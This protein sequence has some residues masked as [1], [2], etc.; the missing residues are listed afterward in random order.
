MKTYQT[1]STR[2]LD[3][4]GDATRRS[5]LDLLRGG[6]LAVGEIAAHLPVSRPAVSQHLRVLKEA[7]LVRD[8]REGTRRV[9]GIAPEGLTALREYLDGFWTQALAAFEQAAASAAERKGGRTMNEL[10]PIHKAVEV[11]IGPEDAFRLFTRDIGSWW[12]V[13][14]HSR[15]AA[16]HE[17]EGITVERVEFQEAVGGRVIEHLSD[18]RTLPWAEVLAW[19][20]PASFVLSWHPSSASRP[21]TAVEVRFTPTGSG[22]RVELEHRGW[23]RLGED[24]SELRG[25]YHT[26][27]DPTLARFREAATARAAAR[28]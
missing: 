28:R 1:P 24:A 13:G 23:E 21:P 11:P 27:W 19:D 18:G 6:P 20:P 2:A 8:R 10:E 9:Y 5:V 3:A 12:P 15:A 7:R 17:A 26:G 14:T 22:T 25:Q 16:E 4:L